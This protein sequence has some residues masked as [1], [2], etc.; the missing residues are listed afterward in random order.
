MT[1]AGVEGLI[2]DIDT[3]AIHDGPG[4]RMAVYLK[5]CPLR[6]RWCH[7]PESQSLEPEV[8]FVRG[9]CTLCG[10][11]AGVCSHSVHTVN[12]EGHSIN[13]EK[14][15]V[16]G[17]CAERCVSGALAIKG[18]RIPSEAIVARAT[19]MKPFFDHTG[20]GITLTGGEVTGQAG[21]AEAV[22]AG[23]RR[24]GINTA[25]ET[26]GTCT[27]QQ[28]RGLLALCD[29]VLYDIKLIDD[30]Q[31]RRWVGAS[32]R[33]ILENAR[34]LTAGNVQIR[35][36]L[37]PGITDTDDNVFAIF[38]FMRDAGLRRIALLPYNPS[39]AAK[40]EWLGEPYDI[41]GDSQSEERLREVASMGSAMDLD[42]MIE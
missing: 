34:R 20:G 10:A 1:D 24:A 19:R 26:A 7:S 33:R 31:H 3:F 11:C 36:P 13:R 30:D 27:W 15:V 39:S 21:F 2:F 12:S 8:I 6:C 25:I 23:C 38:S 22:L 4:I 18:H 5:G 29:L 28:L 35:T 42:V 37:I 14:C 16:C 17:R 41:K 32:N 9:R 40:Y